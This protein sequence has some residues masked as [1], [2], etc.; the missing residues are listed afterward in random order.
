MSE[1]R[2]DVFVGV[3]WATAEH[4]VCVLAGSG[5]VLGERR[6]AHTAAGLDGLCSWLTEAGGGDVTQVLVAIEVPH[7]IVVETLLE[8]GFGVYAINPKQ[9]DRFRDRFSVAGAKD[10]RLDALVLASS[11]RT[12]RA[13]FRRVQA[14][15]A[16]IVEL[17]EWSRIRD[18]VADERNRLGNRL[19][20]QL[21]RYFPELIALGDVVEPWF[22]ALLLSYAERGK[23]LHAKE[24]PL[25]KL[26][27]KHR[28]RRIT[29]QQLMGVMHQKPLQTAPGTA[30]AAVGHIRLLIPRIVLLNQQMANVDGQ[31]ALTLEAISQGSAVAE[32][33][34]P[35]QLSGQRD[36]EVLLSLP[37]VGAVVVTTLMAEGWEAIARRDY[38]AIRALAGI[39]PVT[40]R[41]GKHLQ[42]LMRTACNQRLRNA[43]YHWARV[44]AQYDPTSKAAY[45]ALRQRGQNHA[46]SLRTLADRQLA[47]ACAMLKTQQIYDPTRRKAY[48]A[49]A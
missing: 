33:A 42:V 44:S 4:A 22:L 36:V 2:R 17:R 38:H 49:A 47:I 48:A 37:G 23:A 20:E 25:A 19:R 24:G 10:D 35:E 3:D 14:L 5:E 41:S 1:E 31:L 18:D 32:G 45:T 15:P 11:L 12:D 34:T 6:I 16:Q 7:G 28:I 43:L 40:R 30:S 29:A 26:L 21:R 27:S 13:H 9:L 8:R 39:A 46:R